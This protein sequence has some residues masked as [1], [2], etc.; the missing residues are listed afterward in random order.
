M[1]RPSK[2]EKLFNKL[3]QE[4]NDLA[5]RTAALQGEIDSIAARLDELNVIVPA[6][7][8]Q[9]GSKPAAKKAPARKAAPAKRTTTRKTT[10]RR[11][12]TRKPAAKKAAPKK[13]TAKPAARKAAAKPAAKKVAA[14]P[15]AKKAAAKPA[16]KKAAAKPAAKKTATSRKGRRK[17]SGA[18]GVHALGIVDAAI[19]LAKKHGKRDVDA[20]DVFGWFNEIGY[21]TSRGTP[22]R[23][24]IYVSL[25][26]EATEGA[27][28]GRNRI[29]RVGKGQFVFNEVAK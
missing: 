27:K 7:E 11:A 21:K 6:L 18:K 4:R 9:M 22:N 1:S 29:A 8:A 17:A 16:A 23:N 14:K 10:T 15:A 13:T 12:T 24:S 26:R 3:Q 20:G 25:N 19:A 5:A 2:A 28:K